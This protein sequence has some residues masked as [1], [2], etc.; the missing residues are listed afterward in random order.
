MMI[1]CWGIVLYLLFPIVLCTDKISAPE[2]IFIAHRGVNLRYTISGENS[3]EAIRLAKRAGFKAIET[4]VRLTSDSCLIVMH[5][6]T[7]NRTCLNAD[8]TELEETIPVAGK[9]LKELKS[10]YL[11]K[12]TAPENRTRIPTLK[13]YLQECKR[14][15]IFPF[16]EPKLNDAQGSHYMDIIRVADEIMGRGQYIITSNNFANKVIRNIGLNDIRL[17]GVLY[18]STF[19]E[20]ANL[21]N[22]IMAISTTQFPEHEYDYMV[23]KTRKAHIQTESHADNFTHFCRVND[24]GIDYISTDYLAPD[25]QENSVIC[26]NKNKME[27]FVYSGRWTADGVVLAD[28]DTLRSQ[29]ALPEIFFGGIFVEMEIKGR[30]DVVLAHQKFSVNTPEM[31]KYKHQVLVYHSTPQFKITGSE[32]GCTIKNISLKLSIY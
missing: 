9:T 24:N 22:I 23:I 12:A 31:R 8:G 15:H 20:I 19:E 21:G 28:N 7:L 26:V 30:C 18:Q 10:N 4:D 13:E 11:L 27:D 32:G 3:L 17:M 6:V 25:L 1:K 5:D 16:I 14:Q 29:V 2:R